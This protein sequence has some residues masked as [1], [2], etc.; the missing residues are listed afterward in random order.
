MPKLVSE[1][2]EM[3]QALGLE[4]EPVAV[5]LQSTPDER[6][7]SSRKIRICQAFDA[8]RRENV[9]LNF[10][11][12]NCIC[13]GARHFT[14][15][16]TMPLEKVAGV[17]TNVH[18]AYESVEKALESIRKQPQPV[19]MGE[20]VVLSPLSKMEKKPDMVSVFVNPAQ[21]DRLLGLISYRG[22]EPFSYYPVSNVC[23]IITNTLAKGRPEIN[24]VAGHGRG[25]ADWSQG[26]MMVGLPF[27]LYLEA[28]RNIPSS[29]F[30][31]AL[32]K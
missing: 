13:P 22:A 2:K 27:H 25:F 29:G 10:S 19:K 6:G 21:A 26:E 24:F 23:S 18:K 28:C 17:W 31:T 16:E 15:L 3:M 20:Y 7:D 8:V 11:K 32:K 9:I 30:G 1:S 14:G 12:E 4:W 5:R